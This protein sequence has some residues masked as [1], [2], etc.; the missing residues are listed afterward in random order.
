[1]LSRALEQLA[2]P[3]DAR[4]KCKRGQT[5]QRRGKRRKERERNR[6]RRRKKHLVTASWRAFSRACSSDLRAMLE[7]DSK[8]T[9]TQRKKEER[10]RETDGQKKEIGIMKEREMI[11]IIVSGISEVVCF[12][13][14]SSSSH[15]RTMLQMMAQKTHI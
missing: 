14:R 3:H 6:W 4:D 13:A 2:L 9:E 8:D 12:L 11:I 5:R 1:M 7:D 15:L 10:E